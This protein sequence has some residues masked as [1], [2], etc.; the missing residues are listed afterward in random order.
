MS[1]ALTIAH[2]YRHIDI[3]TLN[4]PHVD[5]T[6]DCEGHRASIAVH[7]KLRCFLEDKLSLLEFPGNDPQVS[8]LNLVIDSNT[9]IEEHGIHI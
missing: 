7:T 5:I 4:I 1:V 6:V 3:S 9:H 8:L 2:C